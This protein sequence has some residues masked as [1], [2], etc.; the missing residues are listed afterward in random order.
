VSTNNLVSRIPP[1]LRAAWANVW[2]F[3]IPKELW[4][5]LRQWPTVFLAIACYAW[6]PSDRGERLILLALVW[7]L[8]I[9]YW[10]MVSAMKASR[11][12]LFATVA[13]LRDC[14]YTPV[15]WDRVLRRDDA[16]TVE[17]LGLI[18]SLRR[19]GLSWFNHA[20]HAKFF[21]VG[22]GESGTIPGGLGVYHIPFM[23]AV[24]LLRDD[25][26]EAE[27]EDR[28]CLY[29]EL[30]HTLGEE[31]LVQSAM[32]KGVK[33]PFA[34]MVL[35]AAAIQLTIA[36]VLVLA[37]SLVA[38][39]MIHLVFLRRKGRLRAISEMQADEFALEFLDVEERQHLLRNAESMLPRD[40]ELT[41]TEHQARVDAAHTFV[42]TGV[43]LAQRDPSASQM[44]YFWDTQF[45]SLN[46]CAWMVLLAGFIGAPSAALVR[47]FQWLIVAAVVLGALRYA[48]YYAKSLTLDLIFRERITWQNGKFQVRGGPS[49]APAPLT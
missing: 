48:I 41:L 8:S 47:G 10:L 38:L 14:T 13:Q 43:P 39:W 3:A 36:A 27:V 5:M 21:L 44:Q 15:G 11:D 26:A 24:I 6:E 17:R 4:G 28:F 7:D 32:R 1:A 2:I 34:T 31:F 33:H 30:G 20:R 42:K 19:E 49:R 23:E 46:L 16:E 18:S 22:M 12:D 25:P 40:A 9:Q 37:M 45:L 35:A 29:H